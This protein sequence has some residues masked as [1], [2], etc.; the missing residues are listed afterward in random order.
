MNTAKQRLSLICPTVLVI[1]IFLAI[2]VSR[3]LRAAQQSSP[4]LQITTPVNG[5]IVN[6]G[7]TISSNFRCPFRR[8]SPA[9]ATC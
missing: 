1:S 9:G 7:Q 2:L 6:P 5:S 4:Q 8:A 3:P